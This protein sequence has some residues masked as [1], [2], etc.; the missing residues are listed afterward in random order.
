MLLS[1]VIFCCVMLGYVVIV[2]AKISPASTC[3]GAS[4]SAYHLESAFV[5][6][7][8]FTHFDFFTDEDP[9][10]GFVDY[11]SLPT[12]FKERLVG[13]APGRAQIGVDWKQPVKPGER[14][15]KSVRLQ[16]KQRWDSGLWV[17]H[18]HHMPAG[19][20][21][22]PAIWTN[23]PNWPH[24]GEIDILEGANDQVYSTTALHTD[25]GCDMSYI[26]DHLN[27]FDGTWTPA[28]TRNC[29]HA[30][31]PYNIGCA[32]EG[33][34]NKNPTKRTTQQITSPF[35]STFNKQFA[36]R[37]G[38]YV[39][40]ELDP[41]KHIR[42]W[43]FA[44]HELPADLPTFLSPGKA[45]VAAATPATYPDAWKKP[46][47]A[48]FPLGS[49]C[50]GHRFFGPQ[51]IIINQTFC[52]GWAGWNFTPKCIA[53]TSSLSSSEKS[54]MDY[55]LDHVANNPNAFK[56]AYWDFGYIA[57]YQ[58]SRNNNS[59]V[60]GVDNCGEGQLGSHHKTPLT[61]S[62]STTSRQTIRPNQ[63]LDN[64]PPPP[65]S[66]V[67]VTEAVPRTAV[68]PSP[69]S[70]VP[71]AGLLKRSTI[72]GSRPQKLKLPTFEGQTYKLS[73]NSI[74]GGRRSRESSFLRSG[75]AGKWSTL[76]SR[77]RKRNSERMMAKEASLLPASQ[78]ENLLGVLSPAVV[79]AALSPYGVGIHKSTDNSS[80]SYQ[81]QAAAAASRVAA[82]H[83]NLLGNS[84]K[85][86]LLSGRRDLFLQKPLVDKIKGRWRT[87]DSR[88]L[89]LLDRLRIKNDDSGGGVLG[90]LGQREGG[91]SQKQRLDSINSSTIQGNNDKAIMFGQSG[92][93][94]ERKK[95][96]V[97]GGG[98]QD[99]LKKFG[100]DKFPNY[101][102]NGTRRKNLGWGLS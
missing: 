22:W 91:A 33:R 13:A 79:N 45:D 34:T 55:C 51:Q 38:A 82:G 65:P 80:G 15:R 19:C 59:S 83:F 48:S 18:I 6:A 71:G 66:V 2:Y 26:N 99:Y 68:R 36:G 100:I 29:Y 60:G 44:A 27:P 41:L 76:L 3:G 64:N 49:H 90:W 52:G 25:K 57:V 24:G 74:I 78:H 42:M 77:R 11:V 40:M 97:G 5:G 75:G 1:A 87:G 85:K 32:I 16:S 56:E 54:L 53:Q 30:A 7:D 81:K 62:A 67:S 102:K 31:S 50:D 86:T 95:L 88:G 93:T 43:L 72:T 73:N 96:L 69:E 12:A 58:K 84:S 89:N 28:Q 10:G 20:G 39:V 47:F 4:S 8:L 98:L 70:A 61:A 94:E 21:T 63:S 17:F 101:R 37:G 14:G 23:G 35:G 46:P 9:T 92:G